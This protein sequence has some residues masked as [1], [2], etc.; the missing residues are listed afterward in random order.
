M[1]KRDENIHHRGRTKDFLFPCMP[2]SYRPSF[3]VRLEVILGLLPKERLV[4][5][6]DQLVLLNELTAQ[7]KKQ[8]KLEDEGVLAD[9]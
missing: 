9:Y 5:S 2:R 1:A 8:I 6:A 3:R 7:H 4:I